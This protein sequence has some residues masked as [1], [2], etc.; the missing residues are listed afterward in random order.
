ME[1]KLAVIAI[2]LPVAVVLP[3]AA[4]PAQ[5]STV[6]RTAQQRLARPP[7]SFLERAQAKSLPVSCPAAVNESTRHASEIVTC[8][9][10][11]DR[12]A[13]S[14]TSTPTPQPSVG[15]TGGGGT[16]GGGFSPVGPPSVSGSTFARADRNT[17]QTYSF[18]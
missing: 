8:L 17:S 5:A 4:Y 2:I 3:A 13:T 9:T 10:A 16:G 6:P 7:Q 1:K 14:T 18:E 12:A 11:N 15:G